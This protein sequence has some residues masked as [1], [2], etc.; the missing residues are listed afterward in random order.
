MIASKFS[1]F[2]SSVMIFSRA[3]GSSWICQ[4][5][6]RR[7]MY[8]RPEFWRSIFRRNWVRAN[9]T[10][11]PDISVENETIMSNMIQLGRSRLL[12]WC[13]N[14]ARAVRRSC[15]SRLRISSTARRLSISCGRSRY[16]ASAN[17]S[18]QYNQSP[19]NRMI[20]SW[21]NG[22]KKDGCR[23]YEARSCGRSYPES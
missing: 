17:W 19:Y 10:R 6:K 8:R 21:Q 12:T 13:S 3:M 11:P 2:C 1:I 14:S 22:K 4:R 5:K 23:R 18:G 16:G 20:R 9:T 15:I 7:R